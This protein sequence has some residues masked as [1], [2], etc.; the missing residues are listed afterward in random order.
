LFVLATPCWQNVLHLLKRFREARY[1]AVAKNTKNASKQRDA[2]AINFCVLIGKV[3][4]QRLP[5]GQPDCFSAHVALSKNST[6]FCN[7]Y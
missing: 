1:V 7:A 3:A 2:V 6:F 4:H 5:N